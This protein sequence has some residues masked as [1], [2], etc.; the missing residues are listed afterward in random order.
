MA[1]RQAALPRRCNSRR[2]PQAVEPV[3]NRPPASFEEQSC[4]MAAVKFE[5]LDHTADLGL[6][7]YGLDLRTLLAHAAEG[8]FSLIGEARFADGEMET[9]TIAVEFAD[10][11]ECL[12][13]WLR[14]L[15]AEFNKD[16]FFPV[17]AE[18]DLRSGRLEASV[19]GGR[20]DPSQHQ[21]FTE[22]KAVTQ[23]AL[24]V[25]HADGGRLEAEVIFDV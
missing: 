12:Y 6:R 9:R 7:I 3:G 22:L 5:E 10:R 17:H 11:E 4:R 21:F 13:L 2:P 18:I 19:R 1:S 23:H 14:A 15:L 20:F 8:M 24:I 16:G 25:R